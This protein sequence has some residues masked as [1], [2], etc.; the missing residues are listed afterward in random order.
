MKFDFRKGFHR[1][2]VVRELAACPHR[3]P[4]GIRQDFSVGKPART[5][6]CDHIW[7]VQ[8]PQVFQRKILEDACREAMRTG[9][10]FTDDAAVVEA[11]SQVKLHLVKNPWSNP[12]LTYPEDLELIRKL[13]T[14]GK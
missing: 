7:N 14:P 10:Q 2:G 12:K 1:R 9:K 6:P 3:F 5:A 8:T 4:S 13:S 11:F